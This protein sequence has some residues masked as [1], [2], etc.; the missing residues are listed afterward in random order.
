MI[1]LNGNNLDLH[2]FERIVFNNEKIGLTADAQQKVK[3]SYKVICDIVREDRTVYGVTTGF[4]KLVE[5]RIQKKDIEELQH[6]IIRSHS[7]GTGEPFDIL[8]VRGAVLLRINTIIRGHSGVSPETLQVYIDML[9]KGLYPYVPQK[10]SVGASGDL[11]PLAHIALAAIGEGEFI[12]N[13]RRKPAKGILKKHN[14]KPAQLKAKEGLALINGTQMMTSVG[15]VAMILAL[16]L[17]KASDIIAALSIDALSGTAAAF[18]S[19]LQDI[20]P[21]RGQKDSAYNLRELIKGSEIWKNH[22]H[23]AKVQDAY[24]LRCIPQVHGASREAFRYALEAIE[25]EMNSSTDNPLVFIEDGTV[26][27]GGNFHGQMIAIP[28]DT[29][30]IAMSELGNLSDRRIYRLID[31]DETGLHAFLVRNAGINSGF[32]MLQVTSA[33]LV[34]ENKVLATPAST[35]SIPTSLGQEDHVSMGTISARKLLDIIDNTSDILSI[36]LFAAMTALKLKEPM[37]TSPILEEIKQY[38][39]R[40]VKP[41]KDDRAY[42]RDIEIIK[43]MIISGKLIDIAE[44]KV[45]LK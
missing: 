23:C 43:P 30:G 15:A 7:A 11:A 42:Y 34:S 25:I 8:S 22:K 28:M 10:G 21:H 20:R 24:S 32:M 5:V 38:F 4:G 31:P 18:S 6:R 3:A 19:R 1:K 9:N 27:S 13:G 44:K 12:E 35:D 36:E 40:H 37:K 45:K 41:V 2:V 29:M 16:R 17:L 33:S 26:V 14:I 39:F